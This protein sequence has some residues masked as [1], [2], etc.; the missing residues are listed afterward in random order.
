MGDR[1]SHVFSRK[2]GRELPRAVKGE[3]VYIEDDQG[4]RYIDASGGA[5]VANLGQGREEIARA[6]YDQLQACFY[7]H[8]TMFT[9]G[10]VEGLADK[11]AGH[12]P[13]GIDKFYFLSSGSEAVE[14]SIKLARQI[15]LAAG[16]PEKF[17]LVARWKSYHGLTLGALSAMGRTAFRKPYAPMLSEVEHIPPPYCLRCAY[18][19]KHP[20]CGIRC[21]LALEE[22]VIN[23][24]P[25]I[26]SA[27]LA[28]TVSGATI[29]AAVPPPEYWPLVRQIC[30]HYQVLLIH[31]E[32]LCGLGRTG[33]WFA[34]EHF[35]AGPDILVMGKGLSGGSL[36]LSGVGTTT[37]FYDLLTSKGGFVHG[38]TYSHHPVTVAAGLTAVS[39]LE[40]EGLIER[41]AEM[42]AYLG[43]RLKERL[44]ANP[45]V[46]DIRG[47]GLYWGIEL[48]A[49]K[50]TLKPFPRQEQVT[51]RLWQYLFDNGVIVYSAT[52]MAGSD[53]DALI[54]APPFIIEG[55]EIDLVVEKI[56]AA[57]ASVLH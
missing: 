25:E 56:E 27:F 12:A 30:D 54:V 50:E 7:A 21:A 31:D 34:S 2:P 39:I 47:L 37:A 33:R 19:L 9:T 29:A 15:H 49:D 8:P 40:R 26:V 24:G 55:K 6:V 23:L 11:L 13:A 52:G 45:Y 43:Q 44:S 4:R 22:A 46:V 32:V 51:E 41:S 28:E 5:I 3:G 10:V 57:L 16:R 20:T 42:G 14:T 1:N 48:A 38:G 17:R 35:G 18:G 36:P 53:G